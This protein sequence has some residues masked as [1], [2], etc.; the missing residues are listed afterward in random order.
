MKLSNSVTFKL[1]MFYVVVELGSFILGT[2]LHDQQRVQEVIL[3]VSKVIKIFFK[4][5]LLQ[6]IEEIILFREETLK[7]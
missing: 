4:L 7:R 6:R 3:G 1:V 5:L 2:L